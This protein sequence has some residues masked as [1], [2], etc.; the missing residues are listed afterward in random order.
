METLFSARRTR[1]IASIAAYSR[2]PPLSSR[3]FCDQT[4]RKTRTPVV[5]VG[6]GVEA[7]PD[8]R[9]SG[10]PNDCSTRPARIKWLL[11][12]KKTPDSECFECPVCCSTPIDRPVLAAA[13]HTHRARLSAV[14]YVGPSA[15]SPRVPIRLLG[16][17]PG[18]RA[19]NWGDLISH[20][21]YS[22]RALLLYSQVSPISP[23]LVAFGNAIPL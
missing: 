23:V 11:W 6:G 19:L 2:S 21:I 1:S 3:T 20:S 14:M 5:S 8:A 10:S 7:L 4:E 12:M 13:T 9:C 22:H 18:S 16:T 17:C 15:C